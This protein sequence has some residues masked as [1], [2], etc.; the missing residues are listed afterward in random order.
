MTK[1]QNN[2]TNHQSQSSQSVRKRFA[3][4]TKQQIN[5]LDNDISTT[6]QSQMNQSARKRKEINKQKSKNVYDHQQESPEKKKYLLIID[7]Q[8]YQDIPK[9]KQVMLVDIFFLNKII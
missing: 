6:P 8:V 9:E 3:S 4:Q 1:S 5:N 2:N 7:L